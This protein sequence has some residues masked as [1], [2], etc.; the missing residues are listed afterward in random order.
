MNSRGAQIKPERL[1][2]DL[3][4]TARFGAYGATGMYR[5]SLSDE[6]R[7]VRD[8]FVSECRALSCTIEIDRIGNIFAT[9][10]GT[11]PALDPIAV[12]SHLDTQ[13]AGGRF[14]G[15]LGV[16]AGIEV[17]RALH[18][19]GLR[20]A[21]PITIVNWTNEEGS[22]FS[23][24]MMGSGVF[25]GAHQLEAI[26]TIRDKNDI[27]VAEALQTIGYAG[28]HTPGHIRFAAYL[29]LHI[30][31]GPLL[32]AEAVQIGVVDAVQGVCWLDVTVPGVDAHAGS[33]PMTMRNDALV[34]AAKIVLAVETTASAHAPGV[35]TVGFLQVEPNSR[36]VIPGKVTQEIDLRHPDDNALTAMEEDITAVIGRL[37]PNAEVRRIWRKA[38]T[39][40]DPRLVGIVEAEAKAI[41][42]SVRRIV[43]GAGHDAAHIARLA[44]SAM[45]FIPSYQGLSHNVLEYSSP[46]QCAEGAAV[47]LGAVLEADSALR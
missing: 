25:C 7:A 22:R 41:G 26:N 9:Y 13:P 12:G 8:W 42:C 17:I 6:D 21:H 36:N 39:A 5:L 31:Q 37:V 1:W 43:S 19:A 20:P 24:A 46:E 30:E 29:E 34:A 11:N 44:P 45:I 27:S 14:D 40:F 2:S 35:G 33:R 15:I 16:L 18:D 32:E 23:P 10:P 38:P 4:T 47:L 3:M 28:P